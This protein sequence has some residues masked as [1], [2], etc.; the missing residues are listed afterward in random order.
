MD[1]ILSA[2]RTVYN[3]ELEN[4]CILCQCQEL[5]LS[6]NIGQVFVQKIS[7]KLLNWTDIELR[8]DF[9]YTIDTLKGPDLPPWL[10]S[11]YFTTDNCLYLF[12]APPRDIEADK[13]ILHVSISSLFSYRMK[14]C[15]VAITILREQEVWNY[16]I[17]IRINNIHIQDMLN[18]DRQKELIQIFEDNFWKESRG[19][20]Y[21]TFLA[22][23]EDVGFKAPLNPNDT[24]GIVVHLGSI[25]TFSNQL[26]N[27]QNETVPLS[28][29][30]PSFLKR[31]TVERF[32]RP[33]NFIIDWCFFKLVNFRECSIFAVKPKKETATE[34]C[35]YW[36]FDK[37]DPVLDNNDEFFE[38][39]EK[40]IGSHASGLTFLLVIIPSI[41]LSIIITSWLS[42][43]M[44][45]NHAKLNDPYSD[46]YFETIFY[47]CED[48]IRNQ[49]INERT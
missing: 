6:V 46:D 33:K 17:H 40:L 14:Y 43:F 44:C 8:N 1:V 3:T 18:R 39:K 42:S 21:V 15:K 26:I 27:L 16:E 34:M 11:K 36:N 29:H 10:F 20:L 24:A 30:C 7:L 4:S 45:L 35:N 49:N 28:K 2:I 38:N 41:V 32:F 48:Y 25:I 12:G 23:S 13:M 31:I 5:N 19:K 9:H 47:I 22:A 37:L